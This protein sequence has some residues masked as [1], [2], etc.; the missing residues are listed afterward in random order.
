M[1]WSIVKTVNFCYGVGMPIIAYIMM[2]SVCSWLCAW[3]ITGALPLPRCRRGR[4]RRH[5]RHCVAVPAPLAPAAPAAR[6]RGFTAVAWP[7]SRRWAERASERAPA[8]FRRGAFRG[9]GAVR[10][11]FR[12]AGGGG[13]AAAASPSAAAL[14]AAALAGHAG[15]R[16]ERPSTSRRR[17]GTRLAV[18]LPLC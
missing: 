15:T 17:R 7:S 11:L 3:P 13:G 14:A 1:N 6:R 12:R 9:C 2:G 18:L 5:R 4:C 8:S 10:H 16:A